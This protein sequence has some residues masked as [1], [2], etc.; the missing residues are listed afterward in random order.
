MH[1]PQNAITRQDFLDASGTD[2]PVLVVIFLRG[3]ADGLTL[4]PP[5]GDDAYFKARPT[6][7]VDPT[8]AIDLDG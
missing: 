4:V 6:L 7:S 1:Q 3:G 5:T 8:A 2:D